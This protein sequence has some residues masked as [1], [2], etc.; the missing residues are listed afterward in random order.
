M[1]DRLVEKGHAYVTGDGSVYFKVDSFPSYGRVSRLN[2]RQ[3]RAGATSPAAAADAD[4]ADEKEDGSDFALWKA[5]KPE[6]G[7]VAWDSPWSRGR[8][9]GT[10]SA[11]P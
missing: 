4:E 9:G 10:S 11:A 2:E 3:L 5:W 1:I 7:D 6:D 8:P